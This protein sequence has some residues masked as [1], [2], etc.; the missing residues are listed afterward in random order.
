MACE[1]ESHGSGNIIDSE[2]GDL[3]DCSDVN[4]SDDGNVKVKKCRTIML[5][6]SGLMIE[7][8]YIICLLGNNCRVG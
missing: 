5:I 8:V 2:T 1:E 3:Y 7:V 6:K 4:E